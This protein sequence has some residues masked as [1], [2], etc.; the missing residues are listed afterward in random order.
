[1][2]YDPATE[3]REPSGRQPA[4]GYLQQV[5]EFVGEAAAASD[6]DAHLARLGPAGT[7]PLTRSPIMPYGSMGMT[8]RQATAEQQ[9][10]EANA[11]ADVLAGL[12]Q[13]VTPAAAPPVR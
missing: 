8:W 5:R 2:V 12:F 1:M 6:L 7:P 10:G 9:R 13:P 4:P 3:D 11:L